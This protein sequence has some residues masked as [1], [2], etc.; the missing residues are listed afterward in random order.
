MGL[1]GA[2]Q[3]QVPCWDEGCLLQRVICYRCDPVERRAR[4]LSRSLS[5]AVRKAMKTPPPTMLEFAW[6]QFNRMEQHGEIL[7]GWTV[8]PVIDEVTGERTFY[9]QATLPGEVH[10]FDVTMDVTV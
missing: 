7:P 2:G 9:A 8:D 4:R 1:H 6:E 3:R 10:E 5:R